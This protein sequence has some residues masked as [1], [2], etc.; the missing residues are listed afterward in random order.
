M[1]N[2]IIWADDLE[3][4]VCEID[5]PS[6]EEKQ[7]YWYNEQEMERIGRSYHALLKTFKNMG[8]QE[9]NEA[10]SCFNARGHSLRGLESMKDCPMMHQAKIIKSNRCMLACKDRT[11][12]LKPSRK[13]AKKA[14]Q[15]GLYDEENSMCY[16][17]T[18]NDNLPRNAIAPENLSSCPRQC[19]NEEETKKKHKSKMRISVNLRRRITHPRRS[20]SM[21]IDNDK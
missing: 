13:H 1:P 10:E 5:T 9:L 21:D 15:M 11:K 18:R 14:Y 16:A 3:Q 20:K 6:L 2:K 12:P 19:Q 8:K 4:V 17:G 7:A